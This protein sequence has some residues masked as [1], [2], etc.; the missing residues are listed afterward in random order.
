MFRFNFK[1]GNRIKGKRFSLKIKLYVG[2]R[3]G[4]NFKFLLLEVK[5]DNF[6]FMRKDFCVN[7]FKFWLR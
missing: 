1:E 4:V 6:F 7:C 2:R 3:E 5:F